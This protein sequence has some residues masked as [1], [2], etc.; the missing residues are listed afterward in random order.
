MTSMIKFFAMILLKIQIDN[1]DNIVV[2]D[3][4]TD[5]IIVYDDND[6]Y[7]VGD[8]LGRVVEEEPEGCG[9][10]KLEMMTF[11]MVMMMVMIVMMMVMMVMVMVVM[12]LV[13]TMVMVT[14]NHDD[15]VCASIL[16]L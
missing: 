12:V 7:I 4:N 11:L 13:K 5:K 15:D 10:A 8:V 3:D 1:A 9:D 14:E 6:D 16:I 2:Y